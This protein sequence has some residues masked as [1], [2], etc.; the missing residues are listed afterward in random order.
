MLTALVA[1]WSEPSRFWLKEIFFTIVGKIC[2][3]EKRNVESPYL[4]P[5][6]MK[7]LSRFGS[8]L[9]AGLAM[10][11]NAA[12]DSPVVRTL[13]KDAHGKARV[14]YVRKSDNRILYPRVIQQVPRGGGKVELR[15]AISSA[16]RPDGFAGWWAG[17]G[18]GH[19]YYE[20]PGRRFF[21]VGTGY[22]SYYR[23]KGNYG[24]DAILY[25]GNRGYYGIPGYGL[26]GG[27][28]PR[29]VVRPQSSVIQVPRYSGNVKGR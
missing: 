22:P 17:S 23:P 14:A 12:A 10:V 29:P 15:P 27:A 5:K 3:I 4:N 2:F 25:N 1:C 20:I 16:Y 7:T 9:L 21:P 19:G 26:P 24:A 28:F 6:S 13:V 11:S 8:C 18:A